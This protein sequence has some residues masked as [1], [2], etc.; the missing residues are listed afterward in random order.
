MK[1]LLA[2]AALVVVA[3]GAQA[4]GS[5]NFTFNNKVDSA[6]LNQPVFDVGGAT[7][8]AGPDFVAAIFLNG[9]QLGGTAPFRTG[10]GAGYWNPGGDSSRSVAGKF[11]GDVVTGF[12]VKVWDSSKGA[13]MEASKAAGGHYGESSAFSITLGGAKSDPNLP[14]DIPGVMSNF[15]SFTLQV[16]PEPSVLALG[17]LGAAALLFR[18]RK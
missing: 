5:G 15:Q 10:A 4:Q 6:S 12:T 14:S 8:P 11:S 17:A 1:K 7:K 16:V 13:T 2:I 9:T 18:R 3:Y